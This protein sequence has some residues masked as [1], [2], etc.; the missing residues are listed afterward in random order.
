MGRELRRTGQRVFSLPRLLGFAREKQTF[1]LP[2]FCVG[3]LLV[4]WLWFRKV[5]A[6]E[7]GEEPPVCKSIQFLFVYFRLT[8]DGRYES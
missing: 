5:D 3:K 2:D 1:R 7:D 6:V 8:E 4:G